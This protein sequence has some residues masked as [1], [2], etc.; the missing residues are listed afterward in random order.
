M[1]GEAVLSL[2]RVRARAA[3]TRQP[4]GL[5]DPGSSG[6]H[7]EKGWCGTGTAAR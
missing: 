2:Q 6:C 1:L 7:E 3:A 4:P 5:P